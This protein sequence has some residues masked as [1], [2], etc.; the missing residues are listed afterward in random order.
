MR[1]HAI[2]NGVIEIHMPRLAAG[3]DGIERS[4]TRE[5]LLDVFKDQCLRLSV[6]RPTVPMAVRRKD[7]AIKRASMASVPGSPTPL[8]P[9]V[10]W[11]DLQATI[12]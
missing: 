8:Y 12:S 7:K 5:L 1:D 11:K 9:M 2:Q 4:E 6:Y 3:L 10:S